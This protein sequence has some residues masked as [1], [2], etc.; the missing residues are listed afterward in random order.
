MRAR[1][2]LPARGLTRRPHE[3]QLDFAYF[4]HPRNEIIEELHLSSFFSTADRSLLHTYVGRSRTSSCHKTAHYATLIGCSVIQYHFGDLYSSCRAP[5]YSSIKIF[6]AFRTI[7]TIF[8]RKKLFAIFI[9]FG[10]VLSSIMSCTYK[11]IAGKAREPVEKVRDRMIKRRREATIPA[12]QLRR[13]EAEPACR[14]PIDTCRRTSFDEYC[15]APRFP[16]QSR[17]RAGRSCGQCITPPDPVRWHTNQANGVK[18]VHF[19]RQSAAIGFDDSCLADGSLVHF[20]TFFVFHRRHMIRG[21]R[22]LKHRACCFHQKTDK[23]EPARSGKYPC[24]NM[25]SRRSAALHGS[26]SAW[27]T[28]TSWLSSEQVLRVLAMNIK[29]MTARSLNFCAAR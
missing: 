12:R 20:T 5:K 1:P 26:S 29:V 23:N 19:P 10:R 17:I 28:T 22:F 8:Q 24:C 27:L 11:L 14:K 4:R 13:G 9:I 18:N 25:A 15:A 21:R 2:M 7:C 16:R 6:I 3:R